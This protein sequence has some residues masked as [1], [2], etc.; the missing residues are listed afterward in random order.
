MYN[1]KILFA[2]L[3]LLLVSAA[4]AQSRLVLEAEDSNGQQVPATFQVE[5]SSGIVAQSDNKLNTTLATNHNYTIKQQL[6]NQTNVTVYSFNL[7]SD[8]QPDITFTDTK[9]S[10]PYLE[11]NEKIYALNDSNLIY[12]TA[13]I[14]YGR[15]NAP[16]NILHCS[17]YDFTT[18]DCSSWNINSSTDYPISQQG[19][20]FSFNVTDFSAYTAGDTAPRLNISR[21]EIYNVTGLTSTEK[22]YEGTKI[23]QGL[24]KT[25]QTEQKDQNAAFRFT[26]KVNN[27][28][29]ENWSLE[30][31]DS[32][33][34]E[35][36][37]T[38][39][40][41]NQIWYNTS[42][43]YNGGSFSSGQ[44]SWDTGTTAVL[45]TNKQ[46]NAS[47]VAETSL[48]DT[49]IYDQLFSISDSSTEAQDSDDHVLQ[50]VK[51]GRISV[52]LIKP[53]NNTLLTQN[54]TFNLTANITCS[55][56]DCGTSEATPRYNT[57]E[58][59]EIISGE[60]S[61]PFALQEPA[62]KSCELSSGQ[63]CSL[64]WRTNA[65]GDQDTYHLLDVNSSSSTYSDISE[66]SS[67]LNQVE[68]SVPINFSLSWDTIDFGSLNPGAQ[69]KPAEGNDAM[70]YNITVG[71]DSRPIDDLWVKG[72]DL[73][74]TVD[75]DY[76]IGIGNMSYSLQ[77]DISTEKP[78]SNTYQHVKSNLDPGDVLPTFYWLDV[79]FGMTEG[80]YN[81]T[82]TFKANITG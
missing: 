73:I 19:S 26:F 66:N 32:I 48:Q 68:I 75:P 34:H 41:V 46:M 69:D 61:T 18:T 62:V 42:T 2:I 56:G 80:G 52:E 64:A 43:E 63:E 27:T 78:L 44:I 37:D 76:V 82:I 24:N 65:T 22:K 15:E 1:K 60:G 12:G 3:V 71:E 5:N 33:T 77:N 74:S 11:N 21:V 40:S 47:Y 51:Y 28:G 8:K 20:V 49:K 23:D 45:E 54:K 30:S 58:G 39:W 55:N 9:P 29:T 25:F 70:N 59:Q 10:T 81:G 13:E 31:A 57:T 72:E 35:G 79:P 14:S 16:D 36:V 50:A 6:P 38:G 7:T 17:S 53:P 4:A 67:D